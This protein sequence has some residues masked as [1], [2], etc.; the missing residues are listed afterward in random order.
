MN[1]SAGIL[2]DSMIPIWHLAKTNQLPVDAISN[3][4][5]TNKMWDSFINEN[6]TAAGSTTC[7][8]NGIDYVIPE[9]AGGSWSGLTTFTGT[10]ADSRVSIAVNTSE[11]VGI[12]VIDTAATP[13]SLDMFVRAA[14]ETQ[15]TAETTIATHASNIQD[16]KAIGIAANYWVTYSEG[17][18]NNVYLTVVNNAGAVQFSLTQDEV[19]TSID[20]SSATSNFTAPA[21]NGTR[22]FV[23][24]TS[25]DETDIHYAAYAISDGTKDISSRDLGQGTV[26]HKQ[27][28]A[29]GDAT[30]TLIYLISSQE[31]TT[32]IEL[33]LMIYVLNNDGDIIRSNL[34]P[35]TEKDVMMEVALS[36]D[37]K[38]L[39]VLTQFDGGVS[40]GDR[41]LMID[42]TTLQVVGSSIPVISV[43][44][45]VANPKMGFDPADRL[46][47]VSIINILSPLETPP[48]N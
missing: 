40:N 42:T 28:R 16:P 26:D 20:T 34:I 30:N 24:G 46:W 43:V 3:S 8:W 38:R 39:A 22:A 41:I 37:K 7:K 44:N 10:F 21:N 12:F 25:S 33:G 48:S 27:I 15:V 11:Q 6:L 13:D 2:Y 35:K 4:D 9:L 1:F 19:N 32:G 29:V 17:G 5:E 47:V 18:T 31:T 23:F 36:A 14:D 45:S